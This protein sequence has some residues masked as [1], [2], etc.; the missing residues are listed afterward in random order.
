MAEVGQTCAG[1]K[2]DVA[3]PHDGDVIQRNAL[4]LAAAGAAASR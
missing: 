2:T 4:S 1:D 3:G